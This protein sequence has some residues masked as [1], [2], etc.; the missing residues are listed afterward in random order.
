MSNKLD[1]ELK[2]FE[3]W[4][5][6]PQR[7]PLMED[8]YKA[9]LKLDMSPAELRWEIK[10]YAHRNLIEYNNTKRLLDSCNWAT[11]AERICKDLATLHRV[12]PGRE[13]DQ[14]D[15]RAAITAFQQLF[16]E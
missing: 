5:Y 2:S 1:E 9:A 16:F 8:T 3:I 13:P 15:L 4:K 11:H 10:T 7:A 6:Y 14:M 12:Y